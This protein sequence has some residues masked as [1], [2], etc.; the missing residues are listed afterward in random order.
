[1]IASDTGANGELIE[2]G[3][4]GLLYQYGDTWSLVNA[5]KKCIDNPELR[6]ELGMGGYQRANQEFTA[7]RNAM[8]IYD[9]YRQVL[10]CAD[11]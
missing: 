4:S 3:I 9:I 6:C 7:K 11:L 1:M 10:E 5:I 2:D 8:Q